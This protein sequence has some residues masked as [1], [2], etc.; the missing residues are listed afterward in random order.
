VS[1]AFKKKE[2]ST[3]EPI[4]VLRV[5]ARMNVGGPA[6]QVSVLTRGLENNQFTSQLVCGEISEGEAD[7]LALRDPQL[8][9]TRI[10]TLG[11]SINAFDDVRA[12]W[13]LIRIMQKMKPHIV[14]THTAKAGMLGRVA[15]IVTRVPIRVHT[16]HGHV[17]HGYFSP[18][19]TRIF[20]QIERILGRFS[21]GIVSVGSQVRDDLLA[22]GI[23]SPE[24]Y[25]VIAPGVARGETVSSDAAR[26]SLGLDPDAHVALFIGRL[27][28]IKRPD[29]LLEAFSLVLEKDPSAV[30]LM[31]GEGELF[32]A[33]KASG[34]Y[35]GDSVRF[36]GWRSDLALLFAAADVAVLSSDN[37]GM[38]VTLIEA[39]MAGV[40][41]VTTDVGSARE[42]VLDSETG[43]VVPT[44][45][46][47]IAQA[48]TTLFSDDRLRH[49][50][51]ISASRHTMEN[52][53][54][55]R[56]IHD[57]ETLYRGLIGQLK[58]FTD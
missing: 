5:I 23:G 49:A 15:A 44:D 57:H 30:L 47:A 55:S 13:Q 20:I 54:S 6:W 2:K 27:T 12:L 9:V 35:F 36:L 3:S 19:V 11:R 45:S 39:S 48:L 18:L 43:F 51:G 52:F 22:V 58:S 34:A 33:T 25:T 10:S 38:P 17:L 46:V 21:H 24:K 53:S 29:R 14:H 32:E 28:Q 4:R 50:M 40:P 1:W 26:K 16:F 56:L 31:A 41:C 37:E 8:P 7:F 42:V